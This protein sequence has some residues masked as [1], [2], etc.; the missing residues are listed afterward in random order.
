[1]REL[2]NIKVRDIGNDELKL[3]FL[4]E[5]NEL[6]DDLDVSIDESQLNHIPRKMSQVLL[7]RFRNWE[8]GTIHSVFQKGISGAYGKPGR[9]TV[10][11][12][13]NWLTQEEKLKRGENISDDNFYSLGISKDEVSRYNKIADKH[14]PFMRWCATHSIDINAIDEPTYDSMGRLMEGN[15]ARKLRND[16]N[17]YG[18]DYLSNLIPNLPKLKYST[19]TY[20]LR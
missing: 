14:L 18:S 5:L 4:G 8:V 11:M 16:F 2:S 13:I 12:L 20:H 9:L 19:I 17:N 10:S 3:W 7:E 6:A 1:M 15:N